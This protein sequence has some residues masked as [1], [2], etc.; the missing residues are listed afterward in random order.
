MR[1][2]VLSMSMLALLLAQGAEA[3]PRYAAQYAQSCHL[4]HVSPSGG[5]M[6]TSYG[7]QF[8][9]GTELSSRSMDMGELEMLNPRISD[10]LEVG[11]DFRG[12]YFAEEKPD[13]LETG[14]PANEAN[15]FFQMQGDIYLR[16]KPLPG[17]DLVFDKGLRQGYEAWALIHGLPLNGSLKVG[18]F[19]PFFGWRWADHEMATRRRLGFSQL[20]TD[21]GVELEF[22]PDHWSVALALG[23]GGGTGLDSNT[24]KAVTTRIAWNGRL[25]GAG[26][27]IG[28][29][30]RLID[31][32]PSASTQIG[33]LFAGVSRGRI[34]WTGEADM[35]MRNDLTALAMAQE[36]AWKHRR[37]IEFLLS[38]DF[39]DRDID[40]TTGFDDRLRLG[41]D[42]IP[43]PVM[44]L[45]PGLAWLRHDNGTAT[46]HWLLFDLQL[47]LFI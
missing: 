47:H 13:D 15:S 5:G 40:E 21:A 30:G 7:S 41:V 4:C 42:W 12:M 45:Q 20:D 33:G 16:F 2:I 37:G 1:S 46:D 11:L 43:S 22:H 24:G 14:V 10:R 36:V 35:L 29:N 3:L 31:D 18:Q 27:T 25:K 17:L 9:A 44:A 26:L 19:M 28:V 34:T 23:N 32:A 8:F 39:W 6:R 38:Y